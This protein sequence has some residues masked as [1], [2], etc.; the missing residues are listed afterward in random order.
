ME[1]RLFAVDLMAGMPLYVH[2][3]LPDTSY[4]GTILL[5]PSLQ[6]RNSR[7]PETFSDL[8]CNIISVKVTNSLKRICNNQLN[9]RS[10][11]FVGQQNVQPHRE[12]VN[13]TSN[14]YQTTLQFFQASISLEKSL[15]CMNCRIKTSLLFNNYTVSC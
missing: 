7:Y 14:S 15:T 2:K 3:T 10:V 9:C 4:R 11:F 6:L 12:L 1:L 8:C 5:L 13:S